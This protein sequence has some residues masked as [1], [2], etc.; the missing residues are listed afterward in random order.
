MYQ[1]RHVLHPTDFSNCSER[2][3]QLAGSVAR[4]YGARLLVLHV[5]TPPPLVS[6]GELERV[7][8]RPAGYRGELEK[9]LRQLRWPDASVTIDY[10]LEVGEPVAEI[11]R[12]CRE[13]NS[14]LIVMGTH[15][16]TGMSRLLMGSVAEEVLRKASC[17]V[18]TVKAL[19]A[20]S[21]SEASTQPTEA[22]A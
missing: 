21:G 18:M 15:G 4:D 13:C 17:P 5:A 22:R 6:P 14:D 12:I 2:A 19:F 7:L 1:I 10:R 11:L 20:A 16:R 8:E 3:F 9:K